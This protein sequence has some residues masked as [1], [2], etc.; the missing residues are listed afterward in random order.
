MQT[1]RRLYRSNYAGEHVI[2]TLT[3][4]SNEWNPET[5]YVPNAVFNTHTTSQAIAIGNGESRKNF[6]LSFISRHTGGLLAVDK[7]Q[8]YGCNAL[9]RDFHPDFLILTGDDV[10]KEV[11]ESRYVD[12]RIVY[13]TGDNVLKYPGK[14]YLIPQ[15]L[16]YD[17]G[18][19]AA[20]MA[21]FDGH[22][23][24]FLLGYDSYGDESAVNNVYKDTPGYPTSDTTQNGAWFTKSLASV[25][26]IYDDVEIIRVMPTNTYYLAPELQQLT[27][28]RQVDFREF[29]IEADL[30]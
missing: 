17:A 28:F 11:A 2:G 7:L 30:G 22:K 21:C 9:Y 20:Y 18:S 12:D 4:E 14:L 13:A 15:N 10:T 3:L 19:L 6:D 25:V 24:V 16:Y 5:E 23:K 8:S 27:N 26:R 1:L 29:S